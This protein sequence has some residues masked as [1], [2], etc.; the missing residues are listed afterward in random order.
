MREDYLSFQNMNILKAMR[1]EIFESSSKAKRLIEEK[2]E[3]KRIHEN[4]I[5]QFMTYASSIEKLLFEVLNLTE[6]EFKSLVFEINK[7]RAGYYNFLA[8]SIF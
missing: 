5:K 6:D 4:E 2:T 3:G 8:P 7:V 1:E